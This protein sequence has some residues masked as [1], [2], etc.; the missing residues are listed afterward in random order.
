VVGLIDHHLPVSQS[1]QKTKE[2]LHTTG[3]GQPEVQ[4]KLLQVVGLVDHHLPV[5]HSYQKTEVTLRATGSG[6]PEVGVE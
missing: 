6:Q 5:G 4:V 3:S 1:H 2:I